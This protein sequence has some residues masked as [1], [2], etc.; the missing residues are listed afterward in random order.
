MD[1]LKQL[2]ARL[3][4]L[5]RQNRRL[6]MLAFLSAIV[7]VTA[8]LVGGQ[9]ASAEKHLQSVR[10]ERLTFTD[11]RGRP[12]ARLLVQGGDAGNPPELAIEALVPSLGSAHTPRTVA[13]S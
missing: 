12:L 13:P 3:E 7:V 11:S 10:T 9:S 4:K 1:D 5:E 8:F 2:T 6:G